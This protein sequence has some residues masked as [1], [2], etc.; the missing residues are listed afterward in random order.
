MLKIFFLNFEWHKKPRCISRSNEV[1]FCCSKLVLSLKK[2]WKSSWGSSI[3]SIEKAAR[4]ECGCGTG[5]CWRA[6][7]MWVCWRA[8][9]HRK[10]RKLR[11]RYPRATA[12]FG[13]CNSLCASPPRATKAKSL[14]LNLNKVPLSHLLTSG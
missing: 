3:S 6:G 8:F 9:L 4:A 13:R 5:G 12:D 10:K 2:V 14:G 1:L 11:S 7:R